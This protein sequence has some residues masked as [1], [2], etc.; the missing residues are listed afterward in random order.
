M[1]LLLFLIV[2]A[3]SVDPPIYNYSYSISFDESY[4]LNQ[5][6]YSINGKYFYDPKAN[7]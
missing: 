6:T 7:Q 5:T 4:H 3:I 2:L 1:K